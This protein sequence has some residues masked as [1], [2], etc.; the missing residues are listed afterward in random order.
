MR[1]DIDKTNSTFEDNE[2]LLSISANENAEHF[3]LTIENKTK[4]DIL[5]D[6]TTAHFLDNGRPNGGFMLEG[7]TY[8][9]RTEQKH[10]FLVL[11][12][13]SNSIRIF[14]NNN[15][16]YSQILR[17]WHHQPMTSGSFGLYAKPKIDGREKTIKVTV[18]IKETYY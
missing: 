9:K 15:I 1:L 7:E 10:P 8:S 11:P 16:S 17:R 6:W 12:N 13:S 14:P 5:L 4:T 18:G 2:I 3:T